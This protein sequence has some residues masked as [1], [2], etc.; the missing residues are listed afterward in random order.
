MEQEEPVGETANQEPHRTMMDLD[1]H[2]MY[3]SNEMTGYTSSNGSAGKS[4]FWHNY[5]WTRKE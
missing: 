5:F 3:P 2:Q 1:T 4:E